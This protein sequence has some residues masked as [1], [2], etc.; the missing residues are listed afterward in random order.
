MELIYQ[1]N[2]L[3]AIV[4]QL[5]TLAAGKKI[6]LFNG[7]IGAG[8][9]TLIKQ[10]CSYLGSI[11]EISSPTY[12]IVNEYEYNGPLGNGLIYH[13]DLYRLNDVEEAL[14]IGIEEYLDS[15]HYCLIEWPELIEAL[16]DP[17]AVRIK[18]DIQPDSD[19]KI[20]IL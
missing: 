20:S 1:E 17:S 16:I 10:L 2:D 3:A 6:F 9:T 18:I 11:D 19:R 12:S 4:K 5:L 14:H 15:G 13:L 7:E 8:K